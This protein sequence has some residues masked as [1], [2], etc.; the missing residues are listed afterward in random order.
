ME[1]A[2][3]IIKSEI[4]RRKSINHSHP[5]HICYKNMKFEIES[6]EL[7]LKKIVSEYENEGKVD[8]VS[9]YHPL[10]FRVNNSDVNYTCSLCG[11][12]V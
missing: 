6:L 1:R 7:A 5:N 10:P 3:N 2:I 9:C 4:E 11:K 12:F 8:K